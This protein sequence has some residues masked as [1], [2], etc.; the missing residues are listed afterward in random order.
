M[1]DIVSDDL[2]AGEVI[3]RLRSLLKRDETKPERLDLSKLT[4]EVLEL[5][6]S[7]LVTQR[8]SLKTDLD[9]DLP[10]VVGDRVQLQQVL[11]NLIVNACEA[12][13][14]MPPAERA[15]S[16]SSREGKGREVEIFVTDSG[17]GIAQEMKDQPHRPLAPT[18]KQKTDK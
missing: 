8:V 12:M 5:A 11:L 1:T 13:H 18:Q 14:E 2:R 4:G 10:A 9:P 6:R 17:P 7:E 16:V 3:Q 15:L